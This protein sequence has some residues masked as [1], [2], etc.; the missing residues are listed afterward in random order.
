VKDLSS[1]ETNE[2]MAT[3]ITTFGKCHARIQEIQPKLKEWVAYLDPEKRK[4]FDKKAEKK[5]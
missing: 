4:M 2:K 1:Y 5:V 3:D